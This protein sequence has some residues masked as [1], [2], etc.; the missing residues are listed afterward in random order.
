[1]K[2]ADM[3]IDM[4]YNL[5]LSSELKAQEELSGLMLKELTNERKEQLDTIADELIH[6]IETT[7]ERTGSLDEVKTS[8]SSIGKD[9]LAKMADDSLSNDILKRRAGLLDENSGVNKNIK[10]YN[11]TLIDLDIQ[12]NLKGDSIISRVLYRVPL[13]NYGLRK[14]KKFMKKIETGQQFIQSLNRQVEEDLDNLE[15]DLHSLNAESQNAVEQIKKGNEYIYL[16]ETLR[17]KLEQKV[18]VLRNENSDD[19]KKYADIIERNLVVSTATREQDIKATLIT[20]HYALQAIKS[21]KTSNEEVIQQLQRNRETALPIISTTLIAVQAA[22]TNKNAIQLIN[23]TR[24]LTNSLMNELGDLMQKNQADLHKIQS[25]SPIDINSLMANRKKLEK[26]QEEHDQF[27]SKQTIRIKENIAQLD[28]SL[29][30]MKEHSAELREEELNKGLELA[31]KLLE[32]Q[33]NA[34]GSANVQ[35]G[36]GTGSLSKSIEL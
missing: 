16:T 20:K 27:I 29:K 28:N 35:S 1:M 26:M 9:F 15:K 2:D 21:L 10:K 14:T 12:K 32:K 17:K 30:R 25:T 8:I 36:S 11:E 4:E 33:Q 34:N 6:S 22:E 7:R 5:S 18:D 31:D 23:A 24:G 13:L 3:A 19:A